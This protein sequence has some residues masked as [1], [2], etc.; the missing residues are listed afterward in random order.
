MSLFLLAALLLLKVAL[1]TYFLSLEVRLFWFFNVLKVSE[2]QFIPV[3]S[4][5][6]THLLLYKF[7]I[8]ILIKVFIGTKMSLVVLWGKFPSIDLIEIQDFICLIGIGHTE[9]LCHVFRIEISAR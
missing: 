6:E 7:S 5:C 8:I 4:C 2:E 3:F 9:A 1:I